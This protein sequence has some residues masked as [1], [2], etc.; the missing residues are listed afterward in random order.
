MTNASMLTL[1][2]LLSGVIVAAAAFPAVAMSGLAAKA[3]GESFDALPSQL[4]KATAPQISTM[5]AA[6]GK[7]PIAV[8]YDEFRS[9]VPLK[10]ISKNMLDAI[11]AAED[12]KFYEHNGV[13]LKGVARAFVSNNSADNDGQQGASTLTMQYVRMTLSYS[14]QNFQEV[15]DATEDTPQ[16]K[17]TEM[18]YALQ[19]EK[20]MSKGEILQGYLNQAPF[21]NGAYGISAGAQVY[22][23]KKPKDLSIAEAALLAG[24]VKSP[25]DNSPTTARGYPRALERRNWVI[26]NMRDLHMITPEQA[27]AAT[28]VK[29]G[30]TAKRTSRG[31]TGVKTNAWG[32]FCDYF[33]RWWLSREEFGKNEYERERRLKTG[34]YRIQASMDVTAQAAARANIADHIGTNNRDAL[35]LA[36]V[37]PGTGRV[38]ALAANR[39][40]KLDDPAH[41]QNKLSSDPR[42]AAKKIRGTYPNTTNPLLSGGGDI[43]GYQAGSVFKMFTM[44]A[45]LEN[46]LPLAYTIN[47]EYRYKSPTYFDGGAPAECGGHYCPVNA[48][49][50]EKGPYNMWT[51]FGSSVNTYFVPLE[52]RVGAEKVVDVAQRFGVKFRDPHDQDLATHNAHDWGSFTLGVS[53]STPLDMANAYATLAADGK[54]CEPTPVTQITTMTGAKLDVGKPACKRATTVDVARAAVDAARCPVGD[55]A[56]LGSCGGHTT[57]GD[58]R[59]T[60][61]HPVFGKTGTTDAEKTASLIVSTRSMTVAGYLVNPDY[62]NH[63]YKMGHDVVNPAV[64]GALH[65]IMKGKPK[66]QFKK[67]NGTKIAKG[68]QRSIPDVTCTS[69]AAAKQR[70]ESAGF[71]AAAGSQ[72]PS[73][74]PAGQAAGTEPAG[75]TVKGGFVSIQVSSGAGAGKPGAPPTGAPQPGR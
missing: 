72:V 70:L 1:C 7:T 40:F 69:V 27:D 62:Q 23:Q 64:E 32:F 15:V 31:C 61:G 74:C 47:T 20:E 2:G 43:T 28:K 3:G 45:A 41:P 60:V 34:G 52:E 39:R 38:Q 75:Q 17:L 53:S 16:R 46:D 49:K 66:Q 19:V 55:Q 48:G 71:I 12:H 42:K 21:G 63:P 54:Y 26:S 73:S 36:A 56:Q 65:D 5:V 6:D 33:Y 11:V 35:L 67:P 14:A 51:G 9:D 8:F 13:D 4:R 68:E 25:T 59:G 44:V 30:H 57:A 24:M 10:D 58:A 29:L 50:S 37:Q 18:K 22:F